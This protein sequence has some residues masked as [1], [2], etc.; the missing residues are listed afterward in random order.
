MQSDK[1]DN[2]S[3]L[4]E[5]HAKD[6]RNN[7]ILAPRKDHRWKIAAIIAAL[8]AIVVYWI[9]S[10]SK[11]PAAEPEEAIVVS[12]RVAKA[13]R[14]P[15]ASEVTVLGTMFPRKEA[16][17]SSK[18]AGQIRLM[19]LLKNK[20]VREGEVIAALEARD[21]QAQR[22]EAASSLEEA[23]TNLRNVI[24]GTI[25][26][27]A[28]QD[29]KALRD[30][31]ANLENA[32]TL[33]ERRLRLY[34]QGGISKKDVDG[35]R[36]ALTT[37]EN[38]LR[39][40]E[41][42]T[43][44][45]AATTGPNDRRVAEAKVKQAQDRLQALD[46]QLSYATIRAPFS[47]VISEQFQFQ[48]EFVQPG[49]KLFTIGDTS[50]MIVKAPVADT[51]AAGLKA[52]DSTRVLPQDLPGEELV[53]LISLVSQAS[54]PQNR[55]VEIWVNL[56]NEAGRL[57][58]NGAAKVVVST[59]SASDVVVVPAAA[60]T[61]EAAN[62]GEGTVMVVDEESIA[63]ETK[64]TVGIRTKDKMEITAGLKGG[65]TV[66]IEGNYSLPDETKVEISEEEEEK[67]P[68]KKDE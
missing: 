65:E 52:G 42:T 45:H 10:S 58:A 13:E 4:A 63:H 5:E 64:V 66:V 38:D 46:A 30:A 40:A 12:V 6:S 48:G 41:A 34:E 44:L 31:R 8:A 67:P 61:L 26:Q 1:L 36:L 2:V 59:Q 7:R 24:A 50:E 55:T 47:G 32:R 49:G 62:A 43:R 68:E 33:Y 28:A 16:T 35:S 20:P 11:S 14:G 18:I 56:K 51:V 25:P 57:R 37:A 21:I 29:E 22:A 27:T 17:V 19:P 39:L 3:T 9:L 53:G 23:R 54:D 15:I 60:V